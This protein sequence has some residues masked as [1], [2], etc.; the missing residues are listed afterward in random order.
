MR[1]I[2]ADDEVLLRHHLR[3]TLA[4]IWPD[5]D[6][7]GLAE[8]GEEALCL[9]EQTEPDI[10]FLDIRMPR[11][12]GVEVARHIRRLGLK[13]HIV[14][15]T[16]YDEYAVN[17]FEYHAV[18]YLLKPFSEARLQVA[19]ERIQQRFERQEQSDDRTEA[20]LKT[21]SAK[22]GESRQYLSWIRASKGDEIHLISVNDVTYF[23]AEDK[24]V[25]VYTG[26]E[27]FLI[28]TPLKEL[29]EQLDPNE[30]WQIHR[31]T[32]ARVRAIECVKK[33]ITGRLVV[34]LEGYDRVLPVSRSAQPL[35]KQM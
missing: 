32:I 15:V 17:A 26:N 31:A 21:L 6:V 33:E 30:F 27:S 24:Y 22:M 10:I 7:V 28:R 18:D 29:V 11:Q 25:M 12:S 14:F 9:C 23:Q 5:L 19:C 35:F 16:A 4:E 34:K 1:A 8:D 2:I 3:K 13:T 20:L